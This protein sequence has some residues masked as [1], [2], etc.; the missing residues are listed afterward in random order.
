[1]LAAVLHSPGDLRIEDRAVPVAGAGQALVR[2][3]LNGL[4]GTDVTEYTKGPMMVPLTTRHPGSG[5]LGPTILGHEFIGEVVGTGEGAQDWMGRRVASGAGVS[6]GRC[7]ACLRGRTNLCERYYTLGLS[8]DG[9]L[10]EFVAVPV[11]TLREIPPGCPDIEAAL[12][13]PLAVGL[14]AVSRAGLEAGDTVVLIGAGA[15]GSFILAGLAGHDGRVIAVD[16]DAARLENAGKLGATETC[17]VTVD[18]PLA[19]LAELLPRGA[20]VVIESSGVPGA[21][22]RA[23]Q[24]TTMGGTVLLVGLT[25]TPQ[26]L[27]LADLVLREITV[28]TTVAHVCDADLGRALDLL[29]TRPLSQLL[30]DRVVPL[31]SVV[32]DALEPLA[33]GTLGGKVLV[34]PHHA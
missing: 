34:S 19:G 33:A 15:I 7:R 27:A 9:A 30:V 14:H 4:C 23:V 12:A 24:L 32:T 20:D 29:A 31:E 16:V 3:T 18:D 21:A 10:A 11:S 5:H 8:T 28:R 17:L 25:K 22:Q 1:M 26:A 6:C 13:Q 2:V